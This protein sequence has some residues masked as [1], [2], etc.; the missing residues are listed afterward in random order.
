MGFWYLVRNHGYLTKTGVLWSLRGSNPRPSPRE[1]YVQAYKRDDLPTDLRDLVGEVGFEPTKISLQ[2]LKT[3][4]FDR[5]A[6]LPLVK[7]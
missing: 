5:F 2:D 4:A 6:T 1:A 7:R 3:C